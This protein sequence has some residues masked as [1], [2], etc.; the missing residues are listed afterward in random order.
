M[1][2]F[3]LEW[4]AI[5][6]E[7]YKTRHVSRAAERLDLAQATVSIA[8]GKLRKK[9]NDPLFTKTSRGMLPTRALLSASRRA[10]APSRV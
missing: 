5:F 7:V 6:D 9:F 1:A 10:S 2:R 3:E 4:L 8:L